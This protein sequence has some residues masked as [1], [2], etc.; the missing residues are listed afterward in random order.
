MLSTR[1]AFNGGGIYFYMKRPAPVESMGGL[2]NET[3]QRTLDCSAHGKTAVD[4]RAVTGPAR[5][6]A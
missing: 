1:R 3:L 2:A 5:N 4:V 6:P